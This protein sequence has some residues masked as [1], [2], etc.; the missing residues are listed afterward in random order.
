[1]FTE[2]VLSN[3]EVIGVWFSKSMLTVDMLFE[4]SKSQKNTKLPLKVI[5]V[6]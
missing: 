6:S 3:V 2:I 1:M 5:T 4:K